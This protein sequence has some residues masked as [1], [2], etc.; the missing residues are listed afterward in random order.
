[1]CNCF[2][3]IL[4]CLGQILSSFLQRNNLLPASHLIHWV[5]HWVQILTFINL[6]NWIYLNKI[7]QN[8]YGSPSSTFSIHLWFSSGYSISLHIRKPKSGTFHPRGP[9]HPTGVHQHTPQLW[10]QPGLAQAPLGSRAAPGWVAPAKAI[11]AVSKDRWQ[12]GRAMAVRN[13][14]VNTVPNV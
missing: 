14:C 13:H 5:L 10:Q 9:K 8:H 3:R 7:L 2:Y 4:H 11:E 1:M 12:E 6:P